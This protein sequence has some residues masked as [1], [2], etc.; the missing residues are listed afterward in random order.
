MKRLSILLLLAISGYSTSLQGQLSAERSLRALKVAEGLEVTLFAAEPDLVNPTAM[1]IDSEGRVWVTE[2]ANYRLFKNPL[3]RRAGDRVRVLEDTNGDGRC[4]KATTFYQDPSLQAPL[5]IAVL[6][7]RV[8]ICQSPELFYLEDTNDDGIADKK[9]VVLTGFKGVDHDH[10][11]HGLIFGPDGHLYFSNG[12][13]GLDV[14]DKQ[15][16]RVWVGRD[17][18]HMAASVLRTDLEGNKLELLAEG[19]RNPFEPAIDSFGNVFISDNDDDGNEQCRINFVMEGANYGYW[20]RRRGNRRLDEVHWN[21]DMPGVMP[22]ILKTGMGSPTGMTFY[23]GN[24]LPEG[25][26]RTLI[27]ADAGPGVVRSYPLTPKGAAFSA[28]IQTVLSC[29]GDKWFRPIDVSTAPDGSIF[30]ADWYD[31]G[32]G[33]HNVVDVARGRIYRLAPVGK[34]FRTVKLDLSSATGAVAALASPNQATR[35]LAYQSLNAN[36][37]EEVRLKLEEIFRQATNPVLQARALWLLAPRGEQGRKLTL[38]AAGSPGADLRIQALRILA[39]QGAANLREAAWLTENTDRAVQRELLL[40]LQHVR[41]DWSFDWILKLAQKFDGQDRYYREALGIAMKGNE[42]RYFS[43]IARRSEGKWDKRFAEL[44]LQLH[45]R[46]AVEISGKVLADPQRPDGERLEALQV[47]IAGGGESTSDKLLDLLNV[48]TPKPILNS[49]LDALSRD[50]SPLPP[51]R[52]LDEGRGMSQLR[53]DSRL[54]EFIRAALQDI[55]LRAPAERLIRDLRL[56]DFVPQLIEAAKNPRQTPDARVAAIETLRQLQT[57][58][59]LDPLQGLLKDPDKSVSLAALR[60]INGLGNDDAQQVVKGIVLDSSW[61]KELRRE[62]LR[63]LGGSRSGSLVLLQL[64]EQGKLPQDMVLDATHAVH[65]SQHENIRLMADQLLPRPKSREGRA[66]PAMATLLRTRGNVERGK[67]TFYASEGPQCFKCHKISGEGRDVGPDLS[68]IGGKL[69]RQALI[70]S[71]LNPSAAVSHEYQVW[72]LR[73][74]SQGYL[75]GYIRTESKDALE[76]VDSNGNTIRIP[77][78]EIT[79]RTKSAASLMP[80]GLSSGMTSQQL[81]DLVEFLTTLK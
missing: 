45:T 6:G 33:G 10:A 9:T 55:E 40:R 12:D 39:A 43:E 71:I 34:S 57:P 31:P 15:G 44:A 36:R 81:I 27:H 38:E 13:Q 17:A 75:D 62:S 60:A 51:G 61:P 11:I 26:Q 19:M 68:K 66:L 30:V 5:G 32:V 29:P 14:T 70:E 20:P 47:V 69:A 53:R 24:L 41:E 65:A 28:T 16:H 64:A 74:K 80:T 78:A 23:E 52:G 22:K 2:A 8:Y 18:P 50:A 67:L 3:T 37:S 4:D 63:L 77:N 54:R 79:A 1:D 35:F 25:F 56:L 46:E 59:V 21:E 72:L 49:V 73:T 42:N 48:R 7:R 58:A 76:L